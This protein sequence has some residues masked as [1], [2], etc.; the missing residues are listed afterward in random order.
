MEVAWMGRSQLTIMEK[1]SS[2][3]LKHTSHTCVNDRGFFW[4]LISILLLTQYPSIIRCF[5][6][7]DPHLRGRLN[8]FRL[9]DEVKCVNLDPSFAARE[10]K[11]TTLKSSRCPL[12]AFSSSV[13]QV[14]KRESVP[15]ITIEVE[16]MSRTH[17][18]LTNIWTWPVWSATVTLL[19]SRAR[20]VSAMAI[21]FPLSLKYWREHWKH[22]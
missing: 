13:W 19:R 1:L 14:V 6:H 11:V 3:T 15:P 9:P 7:L 17:L 2:F 10:T 8:S 18:T 21:F 4:H 12:L 20:F 16:R 22:L 5:Y